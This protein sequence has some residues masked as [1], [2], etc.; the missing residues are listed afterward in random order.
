MKHPNSKKIKVIDS[1]WTFLIALAFLGPLAL[2]LLWRNPRFDQRTKVA[3]SLFIVVFTAGL[4]W[5]S[6]NFLG[7]LTRQYQELKSLQES[8]S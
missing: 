1:L 3:G 4:I 2:P 7:D 8:S 6:G 5:F